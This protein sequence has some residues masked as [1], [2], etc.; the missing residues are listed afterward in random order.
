MI[1][2]V[3][4]IA[5]LMP[6]SKGIDNQRLAIEIE[7]PFLN[8]ILLDVTSASKPLELETADAISGHECMLTDLEPPFVIYDFHS[9]KS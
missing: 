3:I 4:E 7:A 2:V 5:K 8:S 9:F 1:R 6:N